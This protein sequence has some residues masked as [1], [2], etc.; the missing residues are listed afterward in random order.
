[1]GCDELICVIADQ[2]HHFAHAQIRLFA[3][4]QRLHQIDPDLRMEWL[5]LMLR[6]PFAVEENVAVDPLAAPVNGVANYIEGAEANL[7]KAVR[8]ANSCILQRAALFRCRE[9]GILSAIS[10]PLP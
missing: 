1:M 3:G 7:I 4:R 8:N 5:L 2:V 9:A 10:R 6:H